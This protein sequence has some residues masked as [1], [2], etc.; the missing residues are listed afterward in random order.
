M[1]TVMTVRGPIDTHD[2]G[3]CLSHEHILND[4]RS[5]WHRTESVGV[6]PEA[7]AAKPVTVADVWDLK[8]DPF[9]NLDNC[10]LEDEDLAVAEVRRFAALGGATIIEATGL[11]VGRQLAG[12]AR[13][14]QATGV[15]IVAGTGFYLH[16]AHPPVVETSSAQALAEIL[17]EDLTDGDDGVRPGIIG[18]IG[19]SERFTDRERK[20]LTAA[21]IAQ[22]E[23]GLPMQVHLPA[24]FRLGGQVLDHIEGQGVPASRVVLC[25]MNPSGA[26]Q[27]YQ[28]SLADRGAWLQ[29]DM[30][31]AE[32]Y[33]ADQDAQCTSDA[34]DAVHIASLIEAGYARHLLMSSDIFLKSLLRA[35][36]GPGYGHVLQY[37][38][39]R[40]TRLGITAETIKT[41]MVDNPQSLFDPLGR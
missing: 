6:D 19:V 13:V 23:T 41:L 39:P 16:S 27:D 24:W 35:Y 9:G 5:W 37:F 25:H 36:G 20:S 40:L 15:H 11:G 1:S 34:Q 12:L 8:Y 31:G 4:V 3:I 21:C 28:R 38:V 14:S 17:I 22:R 18:E 10:R 26:D 2:M 32:L 7:F 29:Y 33:Y 30:I